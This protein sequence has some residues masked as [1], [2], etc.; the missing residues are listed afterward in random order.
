[1]HQ[2]RRRKKR[3]S[4]G[5]RTVELSRGKKGFGFTISGQAPC[6]LSC[7]VAN[8]P[9]ERV[10]LRP[11]DF[12][13]AV[14][15]RNV[16][17]APHDDVVRLI[18]SWDGILQLQIAENYYSD[19]SEDEAAAMPGRGHH[20][21][22]RHRHV[23]RLAA[24]D[25][26][27]LF[28]P[29][30][31]QGDSNKALLD[32]ILQQKARRTPPR[33][34]LVVRTVVG[35]LGTIELPREVAGS[36]LQAI[37]SCVRRLRLEQ[38]VHTLV[39]LS[40]LRDGVVL[41]DLRG[42][43]LARFPA[44]R[45]AFSG[46]YADDSR[47]LGLVT[48]GADGALSCHVLMVDARLRLPP[49]GL[50][51]APL[52]ESAEPILRAVAALYRRSEGGANASPQPSQAGSNSSNSDSGIGFRDEGNVSDRVLVVD[53]ESQP[54]FQSFSLDRQGVLPLRA[55]PERLRV[56]AMPDPVGLE[57]PRALPEWA[58]DVLLDDTLTADDP[59]P[60]GESLDLQSS[61]KGEDGSSSATP[62]RNE[63]SCSSRKNWTRSSSLRRH[64]RRSHH[65]RNTREAGTVS[66]GEVP[67][68]KLSMSSSVQSLDQV[69]DSSSS[70]DQPRGRVGRW[71]VGFDGLLH[72]PLGLLVFAEFLKKEFSQENIFFWVVCE[73]YR[74]MLDS[75]E[76]KMAARD[77]Y[78]KHLALGAPE[79]VNVDSRA[80]QE[81]REGLEEAASDLFIP[82]QKQIL[83]L[84]KFDC[85]QRFLKSDL[86][87]QCMLREVQ[88]QPVLPELH[89]EKLRKEDKRRRSFLPWHK[90]LKLVGSKLGERAAW[91]RKSSK[92]KTTPKAS[93][94]LASS[95]SSLASSEASLGLLCSASRESLTGGQDTCVLSRIVLPD[96]SSTVVRM[97]RGET[98][99]AMLTLLLQK[100]S[101]NYS[102]VDVFVAGSDKPV[103]P[104][105]D[106]TLVGC[107]EIRVEPRVVFCVLLPNS[108]MLGLKAAPRR[109]CGDVLRPVLAKYGVQLD[110]ITLR[111]FP[112]QG[113]TM[114]VVS[115][116]MLVGDVDNQHVV[117][118]F[119]ENGSENRGALP[120]QLLPHGES[121][122]RR[123]LDAIHDGKVHFDELGVTDLDILF[124]PVVE[125][126]QC[127]EGRG[128]LLPC[129]GV[130]S[131]MEKSPLAERLA[132][133]DVG[134]KLR[135]DGPDP[136]VCRGERGLDAPASPPPLPPKAKQR[137]PPPRPPSR[138][139]GG[140]PS[141]DDDLCLPLVGE[142][143]V[144]RGDLAKLIDKTKKASSSHDCNIS[145]V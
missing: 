52:H 63:S 37:R 81:V 120:F 58:G 35:Y 72:D 1:M 2:T 75:D 23:P 131:S 55:D 9:A 86:L 47:F 67:S 56:R 82:A 115:T 8:S 134:P 112:V 71:L 113:L 40:V 44:E 128:V 106:V 129:R 125:M 33:A 130:L 49:G 13:V 103:N 32:L 14:N 61:T 29:S 96:G 45:I 60:D 3:P 114:K 99:G 102:A 97:H 57:A 15:G 110:H 34:N 7:I 26:S 66:D 11:G 5:V 127:A 137:G 24:R 64:Q 39:L 88:G 22:P 19:S 70:C 25:T 92:K 126:R 100:R 69:S 54:H 89:E 21:R 76:R 101:L 38:K 18:G 78:Q 90:N 108:K 135:D 141:E 107:K 41:A 42:A 74:K 138:P 53:M 83:N 111:T 133:K 123:F 136:R 17:R 140:Y 28:P 51:V 95:R 62:R 124:P 143:Q 4:Y 36:R 80:Q 79:P 73:Q 119:K 65:R 12:L 6:I 98:V 50:R 43:A 94:D 122:V 10:G 77:I 139:L 91:A 117:V 132:Q 105:V 84:M 109:S 93:A 85:Y 48:R 16:S 20:T 118:Q 142:A 46:A 104:S 116:T 68:E 27:G 144:Q 121:V 145:F 87:K 59:C 30:A 31:C